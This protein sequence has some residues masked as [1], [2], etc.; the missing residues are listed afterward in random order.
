[1]GSARESGHAIGELL[2]LVES[3]TD[4]PLSLNKLLAPLPFGIETLCVDARH[5][6][7][8]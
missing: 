1:M 2:A 5:I 4:V 3:E 6:T 8:V 7:C